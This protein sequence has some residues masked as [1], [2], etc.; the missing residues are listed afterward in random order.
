ME[1]TTF[2]TWAKAFAMLMSR[3][4][5]VGALLSGALTHHGLADAGAKQGKHANGR[6]SMGGRNAVTEGNKNCDPA[7]GACQTCHKGSCKKKKNGKKKC[8]PGTCQ[9]LA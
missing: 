4:L 7:C 1:N 2:D 5:T 6:S 8:K 3:R 9:P